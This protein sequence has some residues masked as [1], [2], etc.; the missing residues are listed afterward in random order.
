MVE[1]LKNKE[2][3]KIKFICWFSAHWFDLHD[4]FICCGGDG[5][6][7]HFYKYICWNCKKV[8]SI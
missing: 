4:Y 7:S 5:Y 2:C 1:D 6:P 8:F 3:I